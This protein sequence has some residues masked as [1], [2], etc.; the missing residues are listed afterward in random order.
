MTQMSLNNL[1]INLS[2]LGK[3]QLNDRMTTHTTEVRKGPLKSVFKEKNTI[4]VSERKVKSPLTG[5]MVIN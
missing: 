2:Q 4:P 3:G 1:G 5:L